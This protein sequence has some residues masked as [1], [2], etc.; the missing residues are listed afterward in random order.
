MGDLKQKLM[1]QD[2]E[3]AE[4]QKGERE[5]RE[6]LSSAISV[7]ADGGLLGKNEKDWGCREGGTWGWCAV[8][9]PEKRDLLENGNE[10]GGYDAHSELIHSDSGVVKGTDKRGVTNNHTEQ[11][12]IIKAI[13]AMPE[14]WSGTIYTDSRT[15]LLR[16]Q[17]DYQIHN[18]G[19]NRKVTSEKGLPPNISRRSKEAVQRLGKRVKFVLLQGHPTNEELAQGWG[20]RR[21]LP[22]SKWNDLCDELCN[23][24]R[25][26]YF[27]EKQRSLTEKLEEVGDGL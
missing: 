21:D 1:D 17:C 9:A 4:I 13:E 2:A 14:N 7:Y 11:I 6:K 18:L 19:F 5:L 20:N 3:K 23:E 22:V 10:I 8:S 27:K 26:N 16:V 12:A 15:A 24:A 25:D